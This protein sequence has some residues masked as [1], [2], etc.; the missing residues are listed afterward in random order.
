MDERGPNKHKDFIERGSEEAQEITIAQVP[1]HE[2]RPKEGIVAKQK[3]ER[4]QK[5]RDSDARLICF[6]PGFSNDLEAAGQGSR[7]FEDNSPIEQDGVLL[8]P[9]Q[10]VFDWIMGQPAYF[11]ALFHA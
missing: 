6:I 11:N 10:E 7:L 8:I 1:F 3:S 9:V 4:L 2:N 5:Y